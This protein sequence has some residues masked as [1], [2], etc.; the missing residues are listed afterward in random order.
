[1]E[2]RNSE[3]KL[4]IDDPDRVRGAIERIAAASTRRRGLTGTGPMTTSCRDL[5][6]DA[7]GRTS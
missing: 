5:V 1:M 4:R 7:R 2:I 3:I 6:G